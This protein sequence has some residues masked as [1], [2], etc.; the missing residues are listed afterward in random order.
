MLSLHQVVRVTKDVPE[1]KVKKGMVGAVVE[2]FEVP[3][4]AF[5]VEF[6]DAEGGTV[7]LATLT[8]EA[9]EVVPG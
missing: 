4:R 1:E 8:E 6:T 7:L 3:R 2:V 9:L 5:E